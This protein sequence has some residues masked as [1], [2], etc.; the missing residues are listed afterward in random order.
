MSTFFVEPKA[1]LRNIIEP[2][3]LKFK[4]YAEALMV[5][6]ETWS[7]QT[8]TQLSVKWIRAT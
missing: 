1:L 6:Y 2:Y 4:G 8:Y 5:N 7:S 3:I